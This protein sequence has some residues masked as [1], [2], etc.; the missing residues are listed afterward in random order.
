M[1]W[2]DEITNQ[3]DSPAASRIRI[4]GPSE[5]YETWA[6]VEKLMLPRPLLSMDDSITSDAT[7]RT[8]DTTRSLA[9]LYA[10]A[11]LDVHS[12]VSPTV[13]EQESPDFPK[14]SP[15]LLSS[16]S[17]PCIDPP[18]KALSPIGTGR[19]FHSKTDSNASSIDTSSTTRPQSRRFGDEVP[20]SLQSFFNH[21]MWR[22][23]KDPTTTSQLDSYILVT[24]DNAKQVLAQRFGIRVKR[25]EQMRDIINKETSHLNGKVTTPELSAQPTKSN[26]M[27]SSVPILDEQHAIEGAAKDTTDDDE[28]IL[29][30]PKQPPKGPQAM[31][32][33]KSPGKPQVFDPNSFGRNPGHSGRNS[34]RGRGAFGSPRSNAGSGRFQERPT[35]SGRGAIYTVRRGGGGGGGQQQQPPATPLDL[36]RPIDPNAFS[37]ATAGATRAVRGGRRLWEPS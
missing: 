22:I 36:S 12:P 34:G 5:Q 19:P 4:E 16:S 20:N 6:E 15:R 33:P 29:I 3:T 2:L 26:G 24:N 13:D 32:T 35:S 7:D 8:E 37:R 11:S 10:D 28:E 23:K 9:E 25:L 17:S 21:I 14:Y 30:R 18:R 1:N 27:S 31:Q